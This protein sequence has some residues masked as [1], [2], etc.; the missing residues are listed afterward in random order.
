[1]AN[2]E[3]IG[4]G[5]IEIGKALPW[6]V[7]DAGGVLLLRK[8]MTISSDRQLQIL[9][10]RGLY[11][12]PADVASND[13]QPQELKDNT[14]PFTHIAD[15]CNRLQKAFVAIENKSP[16]SE[17]RIIRLAKDIQKLCDKDADALIGGVHLDHDNEYV[18]GH[19]IHVAILC[20]IFATTLEMA[21]Q[22]K[23][24]LVCAALTANVSIVE[25]QATLTKQP[26]PM[27]EDQK[28][29][30]DAHPLHSVEMLEAA[31][32]TNTMWLRAIEQHHERGDGK[33]YPHGLDGEDIFRELS[34]VSGRVIIGGMK[35]I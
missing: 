5:E 18:Y 29:Q 22:Q 26:G 8:G 25:L 9:V 1:M 3:K 24:D 11:K 34:A 23:L 32:I 17:K 14:S 13:E 27:T 7:Y 4:A 28:S 19:P 35:R 15:F 12:N 10:N 6:P 31:G 2:H 30:M 16:D 20:E 21:D 33:G